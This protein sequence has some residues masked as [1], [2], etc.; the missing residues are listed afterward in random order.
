MIPENFWVG[1][2]LNVLDLR[3]LNATAARTER[4]KSLKAHHTRRQLKISFFRIQ[5]PDIPRAGW[6]G[7]H[8]G[9]AGRCRARMDANRSVR[10]GD[11]GLSD[12]PRHRR[13][14]A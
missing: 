5:N 8:G 2:V 9:A 1:N 4:P 12:P 10:P 14:V 6:V 3:S 11:K 13:N 7:A